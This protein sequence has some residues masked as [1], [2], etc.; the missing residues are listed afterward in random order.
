VTAPTIDAPAAE[1]DAQPEDGTPEG[2]VPITF[3]VMA[4]EGMDTA[5][6]RHLE[7][8][9]ISHR[10]L[11]LTL[12]AQVQTPDGGGGH[13]N[14][15]IVGAVT[16]MTRRPGPDVVSKTTGQP[17][18][19]DTFVWSGEGWMYT[20]VP[21]DNPV[22]RLVKDKA[23]SGNS[24]DLSDVDGAL[25]YAADVDPDDPDAQPVRMRMS[26]VIAATTLVGQPAFPDAYVEL[27]GELLV[28]DGG[29]VI[30]AS[31]VSWRSAE[32]GDDCAPCAL[33]LADEPTPVDEL[34]EVDDEPPAAKPRHTGGM[35]ALVPARPDELAVDGGDPADEMHLTLAYLGDDV[36]SWSDEQ[37]AA[38][39]D[40]ARHVVDANSI[41]EPEMSA[42]GSLAVVRTYPKGPVQARV[43]AHG[44]FNPDGGPDGDKDPASV[45]LFG[46]GAEAVHRM[47]EDSLIALQERLGDGVL[48]EQHS[49]FHPHV[50][51]GY[52]LPLDR[53]SFTG[54]VDFD[55]LRVALGDE[56]T[57]YPLGG[58]EAITA[59]APQLV[60]AAY[61][62]RPEPDGPTPFTIG[63]P[64]PDGF[65]S[66]HG[67]MAT[68]NTCHIGFAGR[69]VTPPRSPSRYAYFHTGAVLT[70]L[71]EMPVGQLTIGA[72]GHA[73]LR[74]SA[75]AAAQHYD[76][77][78]TAF[79]DVVAV[80]GR[81]GI[82]VSGVVRAGVPDDVV[83]AARAAA[84]SGDWRT[85]RG[86]L[87]L[88]ASLQVNVPGYPV[89][90]ARVASG[91]PVALVAA[92][93]VQ[94]VQAPQVVQFRSIDKVA[95][96]LADWLDEQKRRQQHAEDSAALAEL[97]AGHDP[98]AVQ[99]EAEVDL[100]LMLHG[101]ELANWVSK[102]GG[103]PPYI[104]R[105]AKHIQEGGADESRAIASAVNA[106]KR[107][108]ATG[109]TNLP[110]VQSVNAG[111]RAE[112]CA[113][114]ADWEA[115]K[116]KSKA[117]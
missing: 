28:P 52:G 72:D 17:F 53:M 90:R 75:A 63:E 113:A 57:D 69:C 25:E 91:V 3:P 115:K 1:P 12:Y 13:A 79:A 37:R 39:H 100:L 102:A 60:P 110:G 15:H 21:A 83:F 81:H 117:D 80:D 34:P 56:V 71:G 5:D 41:E 44:V 30:T 64:G 104:K 31:A 86:S 58:G 7:V 35:V 76:R 18:P 109:D 99:F 29:Q 65:R 97:L 67:H 116:T 36:A 50:T 33:G 94:A 14:S 101:D 43:F 92:G 48:P 10:A 8:G 87:E 45:Y 70:E 20:D 47:H 114:V 51:A 40:A 111:S 96:E 54:P 11:P 16:S 24:I 85:V 78:G 19:D 55:R 89:P 66:V 23:L 38:V 59:A 105:I 68:W 32:L 98:A 27:N 93:A 106:A 9:G 4:V 103:L 2:A 82:W 42:G 84:P 46:D 77:T 26:G 88:V 108:C 49:P 74:A 112:A 22:Y 6:G 73:D 107:M 61:F 95:R 62:A